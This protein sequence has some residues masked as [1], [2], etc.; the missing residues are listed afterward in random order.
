MFLF[1]FHE[2]HFFNV[3]CVGRYNSFFFSIL[4]EFCSLAIHISMFNLVL[5]LSCSF[6]IFL[7]FFFPHE[8]VFCDFI[9]FRKGPK[10][11]SQKIIAHNS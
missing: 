2:K 8:G 4:L 10:I 1:Y 6:D 9:M 11:K 5:L 3:G 7:N